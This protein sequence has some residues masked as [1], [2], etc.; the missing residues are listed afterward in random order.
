MEIITD[1]RLDEFIDAL[2]ES[3]RAKCFNSI[4]L[5]EKHGKYLGK[6]HSKKIHKELWEL[7]IKGEIKARLLYGIISNKAIIVHGFKKKSQK[8]PKKEIETALKRLHNLH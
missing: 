7:T 5:L 8:T 2:P 4:D 6:P 1:D 3:V